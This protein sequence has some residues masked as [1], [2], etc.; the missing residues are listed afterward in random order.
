M[1]VCIFQSIVFGGDISCDFESAKWHRG[2]CGWLYDDFNSTMELSLEF[3]P[4][5]T[6]NSQKWKKG[7]YF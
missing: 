4:P 5:S 2:Y 6:K 3:D 7:N 1:T